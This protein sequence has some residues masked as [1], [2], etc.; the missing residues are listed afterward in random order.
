M[1]IE[2]VSRKVLAED[3]NKEMETIQTDLATQSELRKNEIEENNAIRQKIQAAI[4]EYKIKEAE[5][6]KEM[7][8]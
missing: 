3:F 7:E 6:K 8:A 4:T 5:F 1:E 2:K